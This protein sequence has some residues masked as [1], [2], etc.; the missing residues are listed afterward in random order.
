MTDLAEL[1]QSLIMDRARKPRFAGRLETFDAEATGD[2][3]MCGDRIHLFLQRDGT[4]VL[5]ESRGCAIMTASADLM[6]EAVANKSAAEIERMRAAFEEM[7]K[8]GKADPTL[9]DLNALSGVSEYRSRI[10]CA[11]LPWSALADAVKEEQPTN[12]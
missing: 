5:H 12:G 7:V 1:Y 9:G 2:N 3:P 8:T 6:A 10:R 4:K 11:T